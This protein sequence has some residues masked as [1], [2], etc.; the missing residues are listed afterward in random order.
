MPSVALDA[1]FD[2]RYYGAINQ[3]NIRLASLY[4]CHTSPRCRVQLG[5]ES[6]EHQTDGTGI[7]R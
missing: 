3:E 5:V 1:T 2:I 6:I 4:S 7:Q